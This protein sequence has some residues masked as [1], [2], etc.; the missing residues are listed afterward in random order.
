M[1]SVYTFGLS[2][3]APVLKYSL[4]ASKLIDV[5][6]VYYEMFTLKVCEVSSSQSTFKSR[7]SQTF[8][9]KVTVGSRC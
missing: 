3:H 8:S 1:K 7:S 6:H 2:L 5:I 9:R 4:T